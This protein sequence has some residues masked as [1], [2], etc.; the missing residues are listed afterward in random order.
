[1][2]VLVTPNAA[3]CDSVRAR[4]ETETARLNRKSIIQQSLDGQGAMIVT[5]DLEEA[6]AITNLFAPEHLSIQT[7]SPLEVSEKIKHAGAI[8]V[9][10][11][12]PVAVGD[13]YAGPNH[14]LLTQRSAR[15]SSP[16]TAEDFRKVSSLLSYSEERLKRDADAIMTLAKVEQLD[17]HARSV[18]VRVRE[19]SE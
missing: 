5:R 16:L 12:T 10:P 2:S 4:L 11:M 15:F 19:E 3:L 17:A 14:I 7:E 1:M 8:M 9:G 6:I 13:Y 18:E